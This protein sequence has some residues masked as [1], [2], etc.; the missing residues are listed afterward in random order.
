MFLLEKYCTENNYEIN[1]YLNEKLECFLN[2][3]PNFEKTFEG[4]LKTPT[5]IINEFYFS[6][7][8]L[9]SMNFKEKKLTKLKFSHQNLT[10]LYDFIQSNYKN[11][12][13]MID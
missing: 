13:G 9:N 12:K 8:L 11:S 6:D 4:Y 2:K 3:N 5:E 1:S 10:L 7:D